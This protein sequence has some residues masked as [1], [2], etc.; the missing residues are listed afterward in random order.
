MGGSV[1]DSGV[2]N[3]DTGVCV[4]GDCF[5]TFGV[6]LGLGERGTDLGGVGIESVDSNGELS[7]HFP[8]MSRRLYMVF[9]W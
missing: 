1:T 2:H 8:R 6:V 9:N 7:I 4:T 5:S 3:T